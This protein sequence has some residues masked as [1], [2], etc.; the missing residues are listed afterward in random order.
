MINIKYDFYRQQAV[1]RLSHSLIDPQLFSHTAYVK[2]FATLTR[3]AVN[4]VC[5]QCNVISSPFPNSLPLSISSSFSNS[6]SIFS[7]QGWQADTTCAG[8]I[9]TAFWLHFNYILTTCWLHSDY[10][11]MTTF[12]LHSGYILT[13]YW[14]NSDY[15]LATK[16]LHSDY[17][18]T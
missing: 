12:W 10:I 3:K 11:L 2:I 5:Q 17:I 6:L 8:L 16:W 14:L 4:W 1:T 9:L 15:I 18:L 13:K 7:Q